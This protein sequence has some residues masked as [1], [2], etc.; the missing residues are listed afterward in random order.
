[1]REFLLALPDSFQ[2]SGGGGM[3]FLNAC[4]DRN[5]VQWGEHRD[6][7]QLFCLGTALK[8]CS[9]CLPRDM[10]DALPGGMPYYVVKASR[11]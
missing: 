9:L 10:W 2:A 6:I 11:E 4:M 5:G 3:S 7:E 8:L 1:M